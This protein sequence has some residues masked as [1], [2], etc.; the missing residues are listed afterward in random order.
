MSKIGFRCESRTNS[1]CH[2]GFSCPSVVGTTGY[3]LVVLSVC[4]LRFEFEDHFL[5]DDHGSCSRLSLFR[6]PGSSCVLEC[7]REAT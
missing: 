6:R 4:V 3:S 7:M 5:C 2:L 1:A